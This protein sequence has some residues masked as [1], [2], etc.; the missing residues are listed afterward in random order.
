MR[1]LW[2]LYFVVSLFDLYLT[3]LFLDPTTEGNPIAS[4]IWSIFGLT[5]IV[6]YKIFMVFC[7]V[8]PI[9]KYIQKKNIKAAKTIIIIGIISTFIT[10]VLFGAMII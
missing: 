10:C 1:K 2:L 4:K 6:F 3:L 9:C 7:V 5:G 8:Y